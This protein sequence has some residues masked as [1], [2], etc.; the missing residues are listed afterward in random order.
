MKNL[1]KCLATMTIQQKIYWI[2][3][4]TKIIMKS[5]L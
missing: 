4:I 2:N 1:L 5:L 3:D